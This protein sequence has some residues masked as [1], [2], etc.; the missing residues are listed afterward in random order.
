[1]GRCVGRYVHAGGRPEGELDAVAFDMPAFNVEIA[2][3]HDILLCV[4]GWLRC[5][6]KPHGGEVTYPG[7]R[8]AEG[9]GGPPECESP[10][11]EWAGQIT[12]DF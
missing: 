1:M 12:H 9:L 7:A 10:P 6:D 5:P 4:L 2:G 3:A 8:Q 11:H